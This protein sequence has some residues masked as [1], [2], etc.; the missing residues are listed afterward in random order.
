MFLIVQENLDKMNDIFKILNFK[1]KVQ[2]ENYEIC[3]SILSNFLIFVVGILMQLKIKLIFD[4]VNCW[5]LIYFLYN[6]LLDFLRESQV[7]FRKENIQLYGFY[8]ME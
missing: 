1:I 5:S 3:I 6:Y 4:F 8:G 2:F 7:I